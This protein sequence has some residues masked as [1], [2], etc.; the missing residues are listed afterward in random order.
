MRA[1]EERI[2]DMNVHAGNVPGTA[3]PGCAW[4]V[5]CGVYT[6]DIVLVLGPFADW[7]RREQAE[8]DHRHHRRKQEIDTRA[9]QPEVSNNAHFI[10]GM[11]DYSRRKT[12]EKGAG[13]R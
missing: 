13:S 4:S 10:D 11:R 8:M 2:L 9:R 1:G 12:K 7:R 3:G 5:A 6:E